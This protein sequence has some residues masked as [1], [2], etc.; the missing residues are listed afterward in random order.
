VET[1]KALFFV[2]SSQFTKELRFVLKVSGIP[3]SV[4]ILRTALEMGWEQWENDIDS[5]S[6][7]LEIKTYQIVILSATQH[8][9]A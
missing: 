4:L 9:D 8:F 2:V 3:P 1:V 5:Y 7:Y 6:Q